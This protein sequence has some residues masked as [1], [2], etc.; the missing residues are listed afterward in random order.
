M[1]MLRSQNHVG[2][3]TKPLPLSPNADRRRSQGIGGKS[4]YANDFEQEMN[5]ALGLSPTDPRPQQP[6]SVEPALRAS[7]ALDQNAQG[8]QQSKNVIV[9]TERVT[10]APTTAEKSLPAVPDQRSDGSVS[11]SAADEQS[12][13]G[14][15]RTIPSI[16]P[17]LDKESKPAIPPKDLPPKDI[18]PKDQPLKEISLKNLA[19]L[20]RPTTRQASVSTLGPDEQSASHPPAG[21]ID[22]PPSP[23]QP[24]TDAEISVYEKPLPRIEGSGMSLPS[25]DADT[26]F[27]PMHPRTQSSAEILASKRKSLSALPPSAPGVQSPLRNEVRYSPGTR[28]SMLSFGSFGRQSTNS[29]GTRPATP[30]NEL[31]QRAS[32]GSPAQNGDS[33]MHKLKSF[34]QRRR[35]S[36]GDILSG[37]QE[38]IQEG[39]HRL[40]EGGKRKRTFSRISVCIVFSMVIAMSRSNNSQ[41]LFGRSR[42][43]QSAESD[44]DDPASNDTQDP[45]F[46]VLPRP[47]SDGHA[48]ASTPQNGQFITNGLFTDKALPA[49]P[50]LDS[51]SPH[52]T[53]PPARDPRPRA[54]VPL[55]L[56]SSSDSLMSGRFYSQIEAADTASPAR[57]TRAKSQPM[58]APPLSPIA[59]SVSDRSVSHSSHLHDIEERESQ[60]DQ[61]EVQAQA[62][63]LQEQEQTADNPKESQRNQQAEEVQV[64]QTE[65]QEEDQKEQSSQKQVL[66]TTDPAQ[67]I[68]NPN[69][70]V[71]SRKPV[72]SQ[73]ESI[74]TTTTTTNNTTT[75]NTNTNTTSKDIPISSA[76]T[77]TYHPHRES[78]PRVLNETTEP[79]ELAM[80]KDDSSEEIVMSPTAYPGQEW[81]PMHM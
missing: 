72:V 43:S 46:K 64:P 15:E 32:A 1:D 7:G 31:S 2:G 40:P 59:P 36:V 8:Q 53:A 10:G 54:S 80:T 33:K 14:V 4:N 11:P 81:T 71:R 25:A 35:A 65:H 16:R 60:K 39:I 20:P 37:L 57:H 78:D 6:A 34:G 68:L 30:A 70:G 61:Q 77:L 29:R 21:E 76:S 49:M 52:E 79:V 5:A 63:L 51:Q 26:G 9:A 50:A 19:P 3:S 55:P 62:R 38:N 45:N 18:P 74:S 47:P 67:S 69:L 56:G 22:S 66:G 28:S 27:A 12:Q 44:K 13:P 24:S 41:G 58:L 48:Y 42:E 17:F 23:L 73:P 75:N